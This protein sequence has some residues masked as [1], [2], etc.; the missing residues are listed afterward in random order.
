MPHDT[1]SAIAARRGELARLV[2][3]HHADLYRYAYRLAGN[4]ADAE[5]LA[6]QTFLVAQQHLDQVREAA[7]VRAWLFA[8]LRNS[9]CRSR[10]SPLAHCVELPEG[11]AAV[12]DESSLRED[13]DSELVQLAVGELAEE[14]RLV[15]LMFYFEELSYKEIAAELEIPVGTV[16]SRLSRAKE[17]LRKRLF[18]AM[19]EEVAPAAV[20]SSKS[21]SKLEDSRR[22]KQPLTSG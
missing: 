20:E 9:F 21:R 7:K 4:A 18:A 15:V 22:G 11:G 16:M 2:S 14:F 6:Q 1:A 3:E 13:V 10:K 12:P 19:E 8:V 17:H 5:D